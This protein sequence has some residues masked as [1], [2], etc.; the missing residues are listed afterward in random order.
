MRMSTGKKLIRTIVIDDEEH[1]RISLARLIELYCPGLT[2]V[3]LAD[4]VE[5][6]LKAIETLNPDLILLDI[7]MADGLG[8]D[9]LDQLRSFDFKVIFV[10]AHRKYAQRALS[11]TPLGYLL[12][13]VDPDELIKAVENTAAELRA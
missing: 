4:G 12:K 11:Y 5:T 10:S 9:L 8:F 3:G 6:G 13:P 7:R 2:V 1:Q